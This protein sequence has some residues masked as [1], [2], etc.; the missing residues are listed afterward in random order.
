MWTVSSS[1]SGSPQLKKRLWERS[2]SFRFRRKN[3]TRSRRSSLADD[4]TVVSFEDL[5]S[6]CRKSSIEK[7]DSEESSE[8][9]SKEDSRNFEDLNRTVERY[10]MPHHP[11]NR[12]D[13]SYMQSYSPN[14]LNR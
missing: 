4:A 13:V 2:N 12:D 5:E 1:N 10:G 11:Y 6:L 14:A 3:S 8:Y 7:S 9:L